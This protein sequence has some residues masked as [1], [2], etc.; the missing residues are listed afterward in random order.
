MGVVGFGNTFGDEA[1]ITSFTSGK[2]FDLKLASF[3]FFVANDNA[4]CG[5][6]GGVREFVAKFFV[7]KNYGSAVVFGAKFIGKFKSIFVFSFGN[8]DKG[9]FGEILTGRID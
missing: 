5:D 1:K 7:G 3:D 4:I 9:V 2:V 6:F 8:G